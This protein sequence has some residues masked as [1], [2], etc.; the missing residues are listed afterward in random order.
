MGKKCPMIVY[1]YERIP[2]K[3]AQSVPAE[4]GIARSD[5]GWMMCEIF[6]EYI[7]NIFQ[8]F[9]F[10]QGVIFLVMVF[11]DGHK[12]HLTYQLSVLCN[13][14][15]IEVIAL[16]PNATR[17]LQPADVAVS[18]SQNVLAE[19]CERLACKT[20]RLITE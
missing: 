20:P 4:W 2:E 17:M 12:S 5:R 10:S 16:S 15:K 9:L 3:I 7:A 19:S 1:P 6:C 11:V 13:K 14:L 8:P 18:S